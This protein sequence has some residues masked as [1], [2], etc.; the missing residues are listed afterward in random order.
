MINIIAVS[1]VCLT[2]LIIAYFTREFLDKWLNKF[3]EIRASERKENEKNDIIKRSEILGMKKYNEGVKLKIA[4]M[5][6]DVGIKKSEIEKEIAFIKMESDKTITNMKSGAMVDIAANIVNTFGKDYILATKVM[7]T[8]LTDHLNT[9]NQLIDAEFRNSIII[10][11]QG[12]VIKPM[13]DD[14][15]AATDEIAGKIFS[16]L[17]PNFFQ[18]FEAHGISEEFI[19]VYMTREIF[20][21]IITYSREIRKKEDE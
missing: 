13:I 12:Q 7:N 20:A 14:V 1:I 17:Q 9:L 2:V 5:E 10:P 19:M 8:S 3:V 18:I 15:K 21:K 4:K 16:A 11:R 6:S